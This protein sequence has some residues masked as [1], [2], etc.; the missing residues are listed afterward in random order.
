MVKKA[1]SK[2]ST[3]KTI[4][5]P[6][7]SVQ[8]IK[9]TAAKPKSPRFQEKAPE[10]YVFWC[11]DGRKFCDMRELAEGL[12]AISDDTYTYHANQ[13]KNDF[14]NWVR[15]IILDTELADSLV[16]AA[17]RTAAAQC[18]ADRLA[19]LITEGD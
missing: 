5:A 10:A 1:T 6:K 13:E 15:D 8:E 4:S 11:C 3:K 12:A 2:T 7:S 19:F 9:K 17:S 16:L 18:V 14:C